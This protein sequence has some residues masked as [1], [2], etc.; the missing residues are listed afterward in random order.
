[1]IRFKAEEARDAHARHVSIN[2]SSCK[3]VAS[4]HRCG[5]LLYGS[6]VAKLH[7]RHMRRSC[8]GTV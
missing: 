2:F 3:T 8:G 4:L 6:S 1:M 5:S 7:M